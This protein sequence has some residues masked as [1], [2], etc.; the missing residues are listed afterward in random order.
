VKRDRYK[1]NSYKNVDDRKSRRERE[2]KD[3]DYLRKSGEHYSEHK[4]RK[5]R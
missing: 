1:N 5:E 4:K 3:I 2:R